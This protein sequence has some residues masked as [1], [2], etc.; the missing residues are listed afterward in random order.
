M[1]SDGFLT[2]LSNETM[3]NLAVSGRLEPIE[4]R[5][6]GN[7]IHRRGKVTWNSQDALVHGR[8]VVRSHFGLKG[9]T[10]TRRT[11]WLARNNLLPLLLKLCRTYEE[12]FSGI[13]GYGFLAA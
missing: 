13:L 7:H 8:E 9:R 1:D 5:S 2:V 6:E 11:E 4:V 3:S 12:S 10:E